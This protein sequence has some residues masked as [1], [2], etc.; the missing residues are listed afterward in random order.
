MAQVSP[1][2]H[3]VIIFVPLYWEVVVSRVVP[4]ATTLGYFRYLYSGLVAAAR[5]A[6]CRCHPRKSAGPRGSR[7]AEERRYQGETKN[8]HQPVFLPTRGRSEAPWSP[9]HQHS[10]SPTSTV[11][12][13]GQIWVSGVFSH[14][15][16]PS[17]LLCDQFGIV[18]LEYK[19]VL[20]SRICSA[21][22]PSFKRSWHSLL[23][24]LGCDA[25]K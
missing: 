6:E 22:E 18:K 10:P 3:S 4:H 16:D 11:G 25:G 7:E 20:P 14:Y 13:G 9:R 17:Y 15:Q 19:M 2:R 8:I 1:S 5:C 23:F 24:H 21:G 12:V